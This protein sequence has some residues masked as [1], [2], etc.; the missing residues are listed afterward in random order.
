VKSR[1]SLRGIFGLPSSVIR[2]LTAKT[3]SRA[4]GMGLSRKTL[5]IA[6]KLGSTAKNV[7]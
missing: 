7:N 6:P 3:V 5:W 2:P 1:A 4:D